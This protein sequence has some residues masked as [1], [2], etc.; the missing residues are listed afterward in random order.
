MNNETEYLQRIAEEIAAHT[1]NN[2]EESTKPDHHLANEA[3]RLEKIITH[4]LRAIENFTQRDTF[5]FNTLSK[6]V[7]ICDLLYDTTASANPNVMVLMDLL[8]AVKQVV[9][10]EI[11]PNLKLPKAFVELRRVA[12]S[13]IWLHHNSLMVKHDVPGKLI[14]IAGIPFKRFIEPKGNLLWGDF[15]WLKSYQAK[16]DIL[17][18]DNG[19]CNSPTEALLSLLIGRDFND[20]RFFIYCKKYI[21]DRL[22][23]VTGKRMRVLEYAECEKLVQEDTQ[24]KIPCFDARANSVSTRLIKWIR[25]EIDF[26]ETHEREQP[27]A[28]LHFHLF[29]NRIAFFFKLLSEQKVFGDTSF[30]D[31]S[32]QVAST[33]LS[34]DGEDILAATIIS[35]AYPKDQKMLTEM[36]TM[37]EKM[38][39]YVR[40]FIKKK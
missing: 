25:E 30:K 8:T 19:D 21:K 40:S 28:K 12:F 27:F 34:M 10:D 24:I 16:L 11:R 5:H 36:E 38:L 7:N 22:K 1:I 3:D 29:V 37:L 13:E 23:G 33:C 2:S 26:V 35:K 14:A 15:T 31:L 32:Q 17:D 4:N 39:A 18:W 6:L 20:D 9:P